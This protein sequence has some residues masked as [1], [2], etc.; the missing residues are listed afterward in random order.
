MKGTF[1]YQFQRCSCL[2]FDKRRGM[3][4]TLTS[5]SSIPAAGSKDKKCSQPTWKE[6]GRIIWGEGGKGANER[7][8]LRFAYSL[9]LGDVLDGHGTIPGLLELDVR[10]CTIV[11]CHISRLFSLL[12]PYLNRAINCRTAVIFVV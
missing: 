12:Y 1:D 8:Q 5:L 4:P 9:D 7:T 3:R 2:I 6:K 10:C 11:N